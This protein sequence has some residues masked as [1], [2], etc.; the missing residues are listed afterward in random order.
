MR[1]ALAFV[2]AVSRIVSTP[3]R[4]ESRRRQECR[5]GTQECVR[6]GGHYGE[7]KEKDK[8]YC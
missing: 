8:W 6:H 5:R 2:R 1:E 3:V 7:F 4:S